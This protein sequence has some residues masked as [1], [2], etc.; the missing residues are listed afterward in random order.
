[1]RNKS[2]QKKIYLFLAIVIIPAFVLWGVMISEGDQGVPSVLG[3]IG[4][5]RIALKDYLQSYRAIQHEIT[6]RYGDQAGAFSKFINIKGEAWDRLLILHEAKSEGIKVT[7]AEVVAWLT[8]QPLF[9]QGGSFN[10]EFYKLYVNRYLKLDTREFEEEVRQIL[11]IEKVREKIRSKIR[12][13]DDDLKTMYS[14]NVRLKDLAYGILPA[15]K[16]LAEITVTDE[17]AAKLYPLIQDRFEDTQSG[18]SPAFEQVKEGVK[19]LLRNQ[20]AASLSVKK[21]S[22][23]RER[24]KTE[25]FEK[26]LTEIGVTVEMFE[27][28]GPESKIE[29]LGQD[30]R[31]RNI[32]ATL[33]EGDLSPAFAVPT[34]GAILK[35]SKEKP[36][37]LTNFEKEKEAFRK[38]AFEKKFD[39]EMSRLMEKLR[40]KLKVDVETMKKLFQETDEAETE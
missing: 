24:M 37:D 20:K 13:S 26:V 25:G 18:A 11:T 17:D 19:E 35:V 22:E 9:T 14:E 34:G 7:D 5:S 28:Y 33:K 16:N 36:A 27:N 4:G 40:A 8:K 10:A 12:L 2:V 15:D 21:L 30:E 3:S 39:E 31:T 1:M 6:L 38:E 23:L 29:A 32:V